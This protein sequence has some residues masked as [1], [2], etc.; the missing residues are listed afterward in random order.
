MK[1][2]NFDKNSRKRSALFRLE[3]EKKKIESSRRRLDFL[4]G[5]KTKITQIV[6]KSKE[7]KRIAKLRKKIKKR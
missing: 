5:L 1:G 3:L 6:N 7:A 4:I 2:Y